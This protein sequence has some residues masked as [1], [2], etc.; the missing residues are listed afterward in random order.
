MVALTIACGG[1]GGSGSSGGEED[2]ADPW[3]EPV[4]LNTTAASDS[5]S[6]GEDPSQ[7]WSPRVTTDG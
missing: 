2:G 6:Y 5:G 4:A 3:I 1:D 7:D